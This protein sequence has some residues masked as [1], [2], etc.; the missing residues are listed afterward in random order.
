MSEPAVSRRAWLASCLHKAGEVVAERV[1]GEVERRVS[2]L[3]EPIERRP[4]GAVAEPLFL[5]LCDHCGECVDACPHAAVLVYPDDAGTRA[6][7]PVMRPER[8]PCH[9]CDGYPCIAA[10][11]TG[12]LRAVPRLPPSGGT[13]TAQVLSR[14]TWSL[15][16][17]ALDTERCFAYS[18]PECGACVG[19]C[20][21]GI[22]AIR[23]VRWRPELEP[24]ECVG[25]GLCIEA[26]PMTPA[27]IAMEPARPENQGWRREGEPA[28]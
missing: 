6:R 22:E 1:E 9:L 15:G 13:E 3:H 26:C 18:G 28:S 25:C 11:P 19:L 21:R 27:A 10:C 16:T 4:P 23:L 17:V 20:P 2:A 5:A 8:R 24:E 7:T 12:A 14:Q